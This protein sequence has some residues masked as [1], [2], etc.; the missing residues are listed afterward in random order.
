MR[1]QSQWYKFQEDIKEHFE[2]MGATAN[3]NVALQ[4]V[5]AKHDI[6][7]LVE[8]Q[9]LG[10]EVKWIIEAKKWKT[11]IPK[12]K[13]M[14]LHSILLDVGA[15]KGFIISEVGFQKGAHESAVKTNVKLLTFKQL[16]ETTRHYIESEILKFYEER[17][18]ILDIRYWGHSKK[19]R[20]KYGLRGEL[21]SG[22]EAFSGYQ[23][24]M[25]IMAVINA[26]KTRVYPLTIQSVMDLQ[27]GEPLINNFHELTNWLNSNLNLLDYQ[28][29]TAERQMIENGDF[30]PDYHDLTPLEMTGA[31]AGGWMVN[32][33][34]SQPNSEID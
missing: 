33:G 25:I 30:D 23:L 4:G 28:I 21:Y 20:K 11:R 17:L 9:F 1:K 7:V 26:A 14:A 12:E 10:T 31:S 3:T 32:A 15:D 8:A 19:I 29:F 34:I 16:K 5:R 2:S 27:R 22:R 24:A 6:D 18:K 13:V